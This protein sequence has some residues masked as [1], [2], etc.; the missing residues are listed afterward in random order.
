MIAPPWNLRYKKM[1]ETICIILLDDTDRC[2][3]INHR[4]TTLLRHP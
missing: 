2:G 1:I 4:E 3:E